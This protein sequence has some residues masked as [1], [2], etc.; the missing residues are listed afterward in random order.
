MTTRNLKALFEPTSI[1]VIGATNRPNSVGGTVMHNL[2]DGG[3]AGPILPVNP[4]HDAIAGVLAYD[5]VAD[6]PLAPDLAVI[7]TPPQTVPGL[8]VDLGERGTR[9]AIVLTAGLDIAAPD[10]RTLA[11]AMLRAARPH[12]LRILGPN[13]IGLIVPD[14]AL[15]AS[16]APGGAQRGSIAFVSQSGALCTAVLG[17][18]AQRQIGFSRFVSLGEALDVDFGDVVDDLASD[19]KTRS[20]LLYVES[21][22]HARKFLSA[23]R[24]AARNK[25]I[26]AIKSGRVAEAAHAAKSHTGALAGADD[27]FEAAMVRAGVLR[28]YDFE[29]LFSV[30][31]TLARAGRVRGNRLAIVTNGGGPGVMAVDALTP[32]GGR[33]A[34]LSD[35]TMKA[36][37][38]ALPA[39]WSKGNPVDIIGDASPERYAAALEAVLADPGADAVLVMNAPTAVADSTAVARTVADRLAGSDKTV[40]TCWLGGGDAQRA[41]TVLSEKGLA[42]YATPEAAVRGFLHAAR[43]TAL[44][45]LLIE[46]PANVPEDFVPNLDAARQAIAAARADGRALLTEP[47]A[48]D[49]LRAFGVPVVESRRAASPDEAV[50]VADELG[51]P[52]AIKI[53]SPDI[54]HKSDVGGVVLDLT[55]GY[56]VRGAADDMLERVRELKPEARID[57]F[58]VQP[59]E[60]RPDSFQLIVGLAQDSIF[61]PF[62]LFGEG[63]G[64]VEVIADKAVA[65][66]PLNMKLAAELV[67]RT[68][69]SKRL[70]GYRQTPAVDM[71]AL[72]LTLI[73]VAQIAVD[74]P[75]VDEL[76]INPLLVDRNGVIALDARI[77]LA[78]PGRRNELAIRPYPRELEEHVALGT[79]GDVLLRPIRPEDEARHYAFLEQLTPQDIR[80]RFFGQVKQLPHSQMARLTQIDY[81][82]EMAFVAVGPHGDTLGVVRT[83]TDPDNDNAEFAIVVRS[84]LKGQGLGAEMMQKMIA[85]SRA[86]GTKR[87]VGEVLRENRR[88][89]DFVKRLGF[90][91]YDLDDDPEAVSVVLD[92]EDRPVI[93]GMP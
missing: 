81:D 53:L 74:L 27:V 17:W 32:H 26:V 43:Y 65:L 56:A 18:A 82:R 19:P 71:D 13:C 63:G 57:G 66:P 89:R 28:A 40:V 54:T 33:L 68:R 48:K 59:M 77:G 85:Y 31:E 6:L 90:S 15:N 86:R 79:I 38:G 14:L 3:F 62:V 1:A 23:A 72:C 88:M 92:L 80:F 30:V 45:S 44:Q 34:E 91:E 12:L 75:E 64:A 4:G 8:I 2:L 22:T 16:F 93:V 58:T 39:T 41:R 25:P 7:C 70:K 55:S 87:I 52:L 67:S 76:D 5:S 42:T 11:Q 61:G 83:V 20:I 84:N 35:E 10:G 47:E 78:E 24:A 29:E 21:I 9:G 46:T 49:V 60:R 37:D 50:A 51:Y 36:L 69:V 73:K